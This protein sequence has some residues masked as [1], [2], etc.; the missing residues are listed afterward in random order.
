MREA[1]EPSTRKLLLRLG[2]SS[3]PAPPGMGMVAP[4]KLLRNAEVAQI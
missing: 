3:V 2:K 4:Q 1:D